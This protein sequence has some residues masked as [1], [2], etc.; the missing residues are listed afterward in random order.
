M[1]KSEQ[2]AVSVTLAA[3]FIGMGLTS[4]AIHITKLGAIQQ[5]ILPIHYFYLMS[6]FFDWSG[7]KS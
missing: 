3:L 7:Q 4:L 2:R 5:N 1:R 6:T